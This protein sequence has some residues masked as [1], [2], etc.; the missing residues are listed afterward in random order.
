[1]TYIVERSID[2]A[3]L[4]STMNLLGNIDRLLPLF[5]CQFFIGGPILIMCLSLKIAM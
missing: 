1:M 3:R 2:P 4:T 5:I